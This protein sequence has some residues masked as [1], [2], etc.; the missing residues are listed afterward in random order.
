MNGRVWRQ[1]KT[2]L[3]L[4]VL[5]GLLL[6]GG[7][8]GYHKVL[9]PPPPPPPTPCVP[10]SVEK[11]Q[12]RSSQVT[13]R[14]FNGGKTRGLAGDV[15]AGLKSRGFK[16]TTVANTDQSVAETQIIGA[17]ADNP[18]VKLVAGFF[19]KAKIKADGRSDRSVDVLV[20][21]KYGGFN[22][23]AKTTIKVTDKTVCLP[24]EAEPS[25]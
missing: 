18:E 13:V 25:S 3:T 8:W 1:I 12:V 14:V 6:Y 16:V 10:Q 4:L 23:N 22:K 15:G 2:P 17:K 19:K 24:S 21:D 5:L 11:G 7:W 9:E 20:G